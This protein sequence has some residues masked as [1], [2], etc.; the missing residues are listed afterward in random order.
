MREP[1]KS[2]VAQAWLLEETPEVQEAHIKNWGYPSTSVRHWFVQGPYHPFW[3]WWQVGVIDLADH[4]GM[5]PAHKQYP[6]AEYE[7]AIFSLQGEVDIDALESGD[8]ENRGFKVLQ[9][10]DVVFHFHKVTREQAAE[11]CDAA[12]TM[13]V[14][15]QSCD[16]DFREWWKGAL[17]NTVE[18]YVLGVH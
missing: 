14:K 1:D 7:F 6:E 17:A 8:I 16:S 15:G 9:P 11:I 10:A 18:H 5:P 12:V 4:P 13:I 2:G 3:H